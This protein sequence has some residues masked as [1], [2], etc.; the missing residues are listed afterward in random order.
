M[1]GDKNFTAQVNPT[2]MFALDPWTLGLYRDRSC[3]QVK[4]RK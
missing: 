2:A 4:V 1:S 3:I